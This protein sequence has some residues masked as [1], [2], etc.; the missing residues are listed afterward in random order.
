MARNVNNN[1]KNNVVIPKSELR[2]FIENLKYIL[3]KFP[4]KYGCRQHLDWVQE[5]QGDNEEDIYKV[6]V[7]PSCFMHLVDANN[8]DL[9]VEKEDFWDKECT[10]YTAYIRKGNIILMTKLNRKL[11]RDA[12]Y[13]DRRRL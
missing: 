5:K 10:D 7:S 12:N 1:K 6:F 13:I 9:V 8:F 3:P 11:P 2:G 4:A